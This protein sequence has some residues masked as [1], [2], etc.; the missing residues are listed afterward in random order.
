[1]K[2]MFKVFACKRLVI[3]GD[4][5]NHLMTGPFQESSEFY[6][7]VNLKVYPRLKFWE[8]LYADCFPRGQSSNTSTVD[9]NRS[10]ESHL[11]TE[12]RQLKLIYSC[13]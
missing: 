9:A 6:F 4:I 8:T 7:S 3:F 10:V 11:Q 5:I 1:M 2:K 12:G 13:T